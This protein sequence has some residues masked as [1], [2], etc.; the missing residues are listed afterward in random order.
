M[1]ATPAT[2]CSIV[3]IVQE[4]KEYE[5]DKEDGEWVVAICYQTMNRV[6]VLLLAFAV[7]APGA[8]GVRILLGV[9]SETETSWGGEV[10]ATGATIAAVEPWGFDQGDRM[11]PGNAWKMSTHRVR[12]FDGAAAEGTQAQLVPNGVLVLLDRETENAELN[13]RTAQGN[14]SVALKDIAYGG[15]KTALGGKALVD[16]VPAWSRITDTPDEQDYPAATTDKA[17][18]VWLAYVE[19]RHNPDHDRIRLT[20]NQFDLMTAKPGGDQIVLKR[21]SNGAWGEAI[22]ITA[23]G[24]DLYR[25]AVAVDGKGRPWVFWSANEA[26][27]FDIWGR[28]VE[29]GKPGATGRI[30]KAPG[31]D[32]GAAARNDASG[33]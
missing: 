9:G 11:L 22:P 33:Q 20:P 18:N 10:N 2:R 30:S 3:S 25:P 8:V 28:V 21:Y 17:G 15:R 26:G 32:L 4:Y 16:R 13:V 27:N 31:S 23:P 19:F 1:K 7:L 14:F 24:G 29:N 12:R 6:F 5:E